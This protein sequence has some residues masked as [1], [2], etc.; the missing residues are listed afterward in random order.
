MRTP[1]HFNS[2]SWWILK[3][4]I[5]FESSNII[6]FRRKSFVK[7]RS[8]FATSGCACAP[9]GTP[10]GSRDLG[11][12]RVTFHNVI[13]G[14]KA[15]LGR[16]LRNFRLRMRRPNGTPK[17]SRDLRSLPVAMVL[18]LLY[19]IL[20]YYYGKKEKRVKRLRMRTQSG[21]GRF[22]SCDFRSSMIRS[23]GSSVNATWAVPIYYC[24]NKKNWKYGIHWMLFW[25]FMFL[26]V[27]W[28]I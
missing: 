18:V 20:Y 23:S 9:K 1:F 13:S 3:K 2:E 10:K 11:S 19:Y 8:D 17:G 26:L 5:H 22:R 24:W 12:L 28:H 27:W 15:P 14:Q 7:V 4:D 21:Q 6:L 25:L 16:I